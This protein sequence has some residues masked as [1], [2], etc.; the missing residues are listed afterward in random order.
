M[1]YFRVEAIRYLP[2]M[3]ELIFQFRKVLNNSLPLLA[4]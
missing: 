2:V 3:L 1:P 4:F